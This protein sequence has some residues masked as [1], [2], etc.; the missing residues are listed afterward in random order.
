MCSGSPRRASSAAW[1]RGCS[2]FT[3]PPRISSCPVKSATS[4]TSRPASRNALAVPPVERISTPCAASVLANSAT[5]VLSETEISA[6]RTRI[7]PLLTT[8]DRVSAGASLI[9]DDRTRVVHIDP[10][11]AS[12]DHADRLRI[13]FVLSGVD[14]LLQPRPVTPCRDRH[15][16]PHD[17]RA[18][19]ASLG[20]RIGPPPRRLDLRPLGPAPTADAV[21]GAP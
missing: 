16:A 3:R 21:G 6:R 17:R 14:R 7:A 15:L 12:R 18:P 1:R 11:C 4:V 8:S 5:P 9:D 2:V 20:A 10:N 13:E 19:F